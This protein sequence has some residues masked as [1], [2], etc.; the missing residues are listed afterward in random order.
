[1]VL[2]SY[3]IIIIIIIILLLLLL[4]HS[5]VITFSPNR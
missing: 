4:T 1:V 5:L 2:F 3:I